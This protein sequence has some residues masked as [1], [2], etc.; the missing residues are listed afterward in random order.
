MIRLK[1]LREQKG[2]SM[3]EAAR[4]LGLVYTTYV[5]YEKEER[6]PGPETLGRLASFY[7]VTVDYLLGLSEDRLPPGARPLPKLV[8]KPRLGRIACGEPIFTEESFDGCDLVPDTV[9]CDYTLLCE[10]DS[11]I[12]ARIHDGDIVYI[13]QQETVENGQIAAVM[14]RGETTLKRVYR[15]GGTLTLMP[16]NPRYAP[17]VLTGSEL[18][19]VRVVGLAVAFTS[20]L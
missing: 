15:Q 1:E 10:G 17:I 12:G 5:N 2:Y 20:R 19:D 18:N 4:R 11:M 8:K 9:N 3:A 13:R 7:E 16:E 6:S 14:V